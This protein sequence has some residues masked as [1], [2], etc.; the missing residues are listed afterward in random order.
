[1]AGG[2]SVCLLLPREADRADSLLCQVCQA[3]PQVQVAEADFGEAEPLARSLYLEPGMW[4]MLLLTDGS[5]AFYAHG[6]YAVGA[7]PLA[8]ELQKTAKSLKIFC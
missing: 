6:G 5:Y 1:M 2:L 8:L 7:V 4:P 3:L